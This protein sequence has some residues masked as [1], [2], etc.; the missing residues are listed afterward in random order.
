MKAVHP[1]LAELSFL[2]GTWT[3][4]G[5]GEY[6]TV[7]DFTYRETSRFSAPPDKPFLVYQQQTWR[8]DSTGSPL[9]TE[10]G[11]LRPAGPGR[12]E[13]VLSQ[14]TGI[15]EI[16]HGTVG[17]GSI[18][19]MSTNV[20]VTATAKEITTVERN[21][22]VQGDALSYEL[23]MAAVGQEHQLHLTATLAREQ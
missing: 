12:V 23:L 13:M 11:Y 21:I 7:A 4:R 18:R 10:S 20:A 19:L 1:D 3:G 6:P 15:A 2:V 14:P 16:L 8:D 9:H 5:R 22:D 17:S